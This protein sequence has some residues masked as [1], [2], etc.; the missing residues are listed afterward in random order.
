MYIR[1]ENKLIYFNIG[2]QHNYEN[3]GNENWNH[4]PR[5]NIIYKKCVSSLKLLYNKTSIN[6]VLKYHPVNVRLAL[7]HNFK[8]MY[9]LY[10]DIPHI[11]NI[12]HPW[13]ISS[14][15]TASDF[16]E[17]KALCL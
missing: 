4:G 6:F 5:K 15:F 8:K 17:A 10:V 2:E 3:N 7:E 13:L 14:I 1:Y 12:M 9:Y 11:L 16:L